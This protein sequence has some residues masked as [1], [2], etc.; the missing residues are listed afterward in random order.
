MKF[1]SDQQ[2]CIDIISKY[3][4]GE[5]YLED[6]LNVLKIKER[7]FRR[8]VK[9]FRERGLQSILHGNI[10]RKPAN[11]TPE[12]IQHKICTLYRLKYFDLSV[13]HFI[14]KLIEVE[15]ME[16][17]PSYPT[18]RSI[19]LEAK[20]L[21]MKNKK[22][23][24]SHRRRK[25]YEKAGVMV[26]IDGSHHRWL[27]GHSP[28]CLTAAVDD[29]TGKILAAKFTE[30]ETTFAAMDV[31]EK[32]LRE[33]GIFQ[34]LYSDRAGIYG[35]TSKRSGYS[36][37]LRAMRD[38]GIVAI[39]ANT[40]QAK[41]RVERL[42][43]TLQNRLVQELRLNGVHDIDSANDF[44]ESYLETYNEKFAVEAESEITAYRE[45][46]KAVDLNEVFCKREMRV[47][48]NGNVISYG[49]CL[50]SIQ[51]REYL[52]GK[53]VEIRMYK[54]GETGFFIRGARYEVLLVESNKRA[55]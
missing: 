20:L 35:G 4:E 21:T 41:G 11:K 31:I 22:Q 44:L 23:R 18:V 1:N 49:G 14:E 6:A 52:N 2:I 46:D 25:R 55:A 12:F 9:A 13:A 16:K 42:F 51:S 26:Q 50:Y 24:K 30:T 19:L 47:V 40:P 37:M 17:V 10:G 7:Q 34:M 15:K 27:V 53:T 28:I 32:I 29:A 38:L 3:I 39:Q 33:K 36:H 43:G 45:L 8:K 54:N 5:I 48:K